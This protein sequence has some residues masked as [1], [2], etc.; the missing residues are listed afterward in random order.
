M[1]SERKIN[2]LLDIDQEHQI[3]QQIKRIKEDCGQHIAHTANSSLFNHQKKKKVQVDPNPS[4]SSLNRQ[5]FLWMTL[6][7][8]HPHHTKKIK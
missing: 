3:V 6:S 2:I 4:L 1:K 5:H 7:L 8:D